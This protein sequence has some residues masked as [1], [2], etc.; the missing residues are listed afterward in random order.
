MAPVLVP[1]S[2]A[3]FLVA[4]DG[5]NIF[6]GS[7]VFASPF[8]SLHL[9]LGRVVGVHVPAFPGAYEMLGADR[10][11]FIKKPPDLIVSEILTFDQVFD[12]FFRCTSFIVSCH[13]ER[14]PT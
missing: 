5:V 1:N 10:L 3:I 7:E 6:G 11:E 12:L 13:P 8:Q 9:C 2:G 4:H 14:I